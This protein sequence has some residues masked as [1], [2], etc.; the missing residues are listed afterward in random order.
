MTLFG[1]TETNRFTKRLLDLLSDEEYARLQLYLCEFPN[2]GKI[3]K[4][5]GGIRK[6]RWSLRGS[7]K[8]GGARIIYYWAVNREKI[9]LLEIY[10]KNEKEDLSPTEIAELREIAKEFEQ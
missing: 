8:S 9:L 1:F 10:R 6:M 2:F 4:G 7:G 5:G 3:I